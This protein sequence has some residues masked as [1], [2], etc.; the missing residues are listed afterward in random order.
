MYLMNGFYLRAGLF[1][2]FLDVWFCFNTHAFGA[3]F[4]LGAV[5]FTDRLFKGNASVKLIKQQ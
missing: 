4:G 2:G 1:D 5:A 3:Y